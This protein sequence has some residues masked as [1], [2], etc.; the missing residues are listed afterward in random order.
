MHHS[1]SAEELTHLLRTTFD[2]FWNEGS[3]T[4]GGSGK[5]GFLSTQKILNIKLHHKQIRA[6]FDE[7][8]GV[9]A[10]C[11]VQDRGEQEPVFRAAQEMVQMKARSCLE[12]TGW[13]LGVFND[14][15]DQGHD[16]WKPDVP[17]K[18]NP[19]IKEFV[20]GVKRKSSQDAFDQP[21]AKEARI[22]T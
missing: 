22:E 13:M 18:E 15:L 9:F 17:A 11:Y 1:L 8:A 12:S 21:N 7:L 19:L 4:F 6:V 3:A 20:T 16:A 14:T 5:E 2:D 10:Y